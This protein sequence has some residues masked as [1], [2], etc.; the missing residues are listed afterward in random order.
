[1]SRYIDLTDDNEPIGVEVSEPPMV[2][3]LTEDVQEMGRDEE[4]MEAA[5]IEA[6]NR[7]L[8]Q[9]EAIRL[10]QNADKACSRND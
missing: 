8:A 1:M 9:M 5:R 3:D 10:K 6:H 7:T 2:I 4:L